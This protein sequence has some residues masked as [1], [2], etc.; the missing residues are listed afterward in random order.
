MQNLNQTLIL[1]V[2]KAAEKLLA[3]FQSQYGSLIFLPLGVNSATPKK[4]APAVAKSIVNTLLQE[5]EGNVLLMMTDEKIGQVFDDFI[6]SF[7]NSL[8]FIAKGVMKAL[9]MKLVWNDLFREL[10]KNKT[11]N[12]ATYEKWR[13]NL[14]LVLEG[15]FGEIVQDF[16][17]GRVP[18]QLTDGETL[19]STAQ[20]AVHQLKIFQ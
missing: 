3:H 12:P 11:E 16:Q 13:K 19:F 18:L 5:K 4:I 2:E 8:N 9:G 14:T 1:S 20:E 6:E 7:F 10:A 15:V 17:A